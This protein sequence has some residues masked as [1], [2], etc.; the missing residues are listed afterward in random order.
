M[1]KKKWVGLLSSGVMAALI[2][3]NFSSVEA[4]DKAIQINLDNRIVSTDVKPIIVNGTTL[5]PI[6]TI[7]NNLQNIGLIWDN[8]SKTILVSNNNEKINL[9]I[10][11]TVATSS[12]RT[13]KLNEP[14]Q[15][16]QSRV[17]VPIR[18]LAEFSGAEV[19]WNKS[20]STVYINSP[21][22]NISIAPENKNVKLYPM[23]VNKY[24]AYIGMIVEIEG[25]KQQF[26]DWRSVD[27][28]YKPVI[29]YID[30]T[31]D[32]KKEVVVLY[33][34]ATGTEMHL[35]KVHIINPTNFKEL[36]I[37]SLD[38]IIKKHIQSKVEKYDDRV[39]VKVTVDNGF[40]S[41]NKIADDTKNKNYYFDNVGFGAVIYYKIENGRLIATASG[42]ISPATYVGELKIIYGVQ[43]DQFVAEKVEYTELK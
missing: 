24:G 38:E 42:Y 34:E 14:A 25:K 32:G 35:G 19:N 6:S 23:K 30:L 9:K 37:E 31:N 39:E 22:Q 11:S 21:E 20:D 27:S 29:Q 7:V 43:G 40:E 13:Y 16:I 5:V 41:V 10:G 26:N 8:K 1:K 33:T 18:F 28:R 4:S 15:L 2:T 12:N 17:M 3:Y 36:K